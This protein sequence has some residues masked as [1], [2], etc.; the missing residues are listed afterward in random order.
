M[1]LSMTRRDLVGRFAAGHRAA[2]GRLAYVAGGRLTTMSLGASSTSMG[3]EAE[4]VF[5][6]SSPDDVLLQQLNA[7]RR[8]VYEFNVPMSTLR[9]VA[10]IDDGWSAIDVIR[11]GDRY[12]LLLRSARGRFGSR[13]LVGTAGQ[14]QDLDLALHVREFDWTDEVLVLAAQPTKGVEEFGIWGVRAGVLRRLMVGSTAAFRYVAVRAGEGRLAVTRFFADEPFTAV[15]L[16]SRGR[17]EKSFSGWTDARWSRDG[18]TLAL[19]DHITRARC[20]R[21]GFVSSAGEL[22]EIAVAGG[23]SL[24]PLGLSEMMIIATRRPCDAISRI[25]VDVCAVDSFTGRTEVLASGVTSSA[26][27]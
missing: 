19:G 26:F 11:R 24:Q 12:A 20:G 27:Q 7:G 23:W 10:Q 22:F 18:H 21:L 14:L 5:R 16:H 15:E 25:P 2:S 13:V 1:P 9:L 3:P 17:L 6:W 4:A 8:A